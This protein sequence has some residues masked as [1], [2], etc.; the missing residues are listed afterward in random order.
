MDSLD[1]M[2]LLAEVAETGSF[3]QGGQRL[4][5]PKSTVSQRIAQL[6]ARLGL[7][8][9]NRSTRQVTLTAA[10]EVY[11]AYCRRVREEA[12]N[13]AVAMGHLKTQ[14]E[15]QLRITCPEITASHFMPRFLHGFTGRH[16]GITVE[17]L[18]TNRAL[19]L[20]RE[21]IDFAFRVGVP[22]GQD[23][24]LRR[25]SAIQ[26]LLVAAPAYLATCT[27]PSHPA[28]LV[29]HRCLVHDTQP[30][31]IF[32]GA[33]QVSLRPPASFSSDSM[34]FLLQSTLL[35]SGIALLPAYVCQP[36]LASGALVRLLPGWTPAPYEMTM[37]FPSRENPSRAQLAFRDHVDG[38]DFSAFAAPLPGTG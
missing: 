2:I 34:G 32:R 37:I 38:Y 26:R 23:M 16:P 31:W 28:E 19:D 25:I 24:I 15:G 36:A 6:E 27:S 20:L 33:E 18:A 10:G 14:P 11:L 8:L 29:Q 30:D 35:G 5:I 21:R 7:R 17:L 13:A 4:G 1:D 3:T 9:L 22:Q 12:Q